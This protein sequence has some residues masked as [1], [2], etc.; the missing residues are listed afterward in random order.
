MAQNISPVL[1]MT[2]INTGYNIRKQISKTC[3]VIDLKRL[4]KFD[5]EVY[6]ILCNFDY[7]VV[8]SRGSES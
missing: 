5:V 6:F 7:F 4:Y 1:M 8:G 2:K 3:I